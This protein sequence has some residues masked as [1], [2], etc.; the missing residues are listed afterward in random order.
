MVTRDLSPGSA[1]TFR[2]KADQALRRAEHSATN[3]EVDAAGV[4]LGV[5]AEYR[6]LAAQVDTRPRP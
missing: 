5:A 2:D 3:G 1:D 6:Q 4:F